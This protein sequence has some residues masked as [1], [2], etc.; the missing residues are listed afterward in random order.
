MMA[1]KTPLAVLMIGGLLS[2]CGSDKTP[3]PIMSVVVSS[4]K[5]LV[6]GKSDA[7]KAPAV[8][9]ESLSK[10]K[11]PMIQVELPSRSY[12]T[13]VVPY[14]VNGDVDTWASVDDRTVSFRQGMVIATRGF[15]PDIL[16]SA[17]PTI[18]Q[19]ASGAGTHDRAYYYVDGG[20]QDLQRNFRCTLANLGNDT[21]TVVDR[22]HT[23]R[24]VAETC[25]GKS[26]SFTNE[27][28]FE[29]GVFLRKSKQLLAPEWGALVLSRVID[30]G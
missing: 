15:G 29:T 17:G 13:F 18:G 24:H 14:G 10:F 5:S 6:G 23:T 30:N 27:Y 2:A 26:G 7:S 22:Q 9:R 20:D 25:T 21:I 12:F 19:I 3:S 16:Q 28:W 1:L 4:A 8:T 11:T